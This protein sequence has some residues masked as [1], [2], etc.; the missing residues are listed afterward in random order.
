MENISQTTRYRHKSFE[1]DQ[2]IL[3]VLQ[4]CEWGGAPGGGHTLSVGG[5]VPP[6]G[7]PMATPLDGVLFA[8][9]CLPLLSSES[10][11]PSLLWLMARYTY[12]SPTSRVFRK[13]SLQTHW[14]CCTTLATAVATRRE[15]SR[16]S[17]ALAVERFL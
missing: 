2:A 10:K 15:P 4:N 8:G 1:N 12:F 3:K 17:E 14:A 13:K 6:P 5:H 11:N 9:G 16:H 7:P